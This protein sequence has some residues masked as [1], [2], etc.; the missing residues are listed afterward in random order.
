MAS[1]PTL[2]TARAVATRANA[3]CEPVIGYSRS[4][5]TLMLPLHFPTSA[6]GWARE[7]LQASRGAW[8]PGVDRGPPPPIIL[9]APDRHTVATEGVD[10]SRRTRQSHEI[11]P[12]RVA[13]IPAGAH[14]H[15]GRLPTHG[16]AGHLGALQQHLP[17]RG[18]P[19]HRR[20]VW[21]D[22]AGILGP[23]TKGRV[24]VVGLRRGK[25]GTIRT[26]NRRVF[27]IEVRPGRAADHAEQDYEK[28][29]LRVSPPGRGQQPVNPE[30]ELTVA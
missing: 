3:S 20:L 23:E 28:E 5:S 27:C 22:H 9:L 21:R 8:G 13:N 7:G 24:H 17:N 25:P 12:E 19:D 10:A 11:R 16:E 1:A 14:N 18:T 4:R 15:I 2:T 6:A 26:E 30:P 29:A